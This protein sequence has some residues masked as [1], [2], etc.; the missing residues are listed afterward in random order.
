MKIQMENQCATYK[1]VLIALNLAQIVYTY[2]NLIVDSTTTT[3]TTTTIT[4]KKQVFMIYEETDFI[5][6]TFSKLQNFSQKILYK[7]TLY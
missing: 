7:Q 5:L 6:G 4:Q 3:T 1:I 2:K